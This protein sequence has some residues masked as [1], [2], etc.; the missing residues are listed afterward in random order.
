MKNTHT[1]LDKFK[2]Y[3]LFIHGKGRREG[4]PGG[5]DPFASLNTVER[6]HIPIDPS[7]R[8]LSN[9]LTFDVT[10]NLPF[11][12]TELEEKNAP[13]SPPPPGGISP[14]FMVNLLTMYASPTRTILY[15]VVPIWAPYMPRKTILFKTQKN[16]IMP[17]YKTNHACYRDPTLPL[18]ASRCMSIC[19]SSCLRRHPTNSQPAN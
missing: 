2:S 16:D 17:H 14:T 6:A 11:E 3:V 9:Q 19:P 18:S 4:L 1:G 8:H 13:P 15:F 5:G 7:R 12:K 10:S